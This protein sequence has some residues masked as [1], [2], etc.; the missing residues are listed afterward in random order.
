[1]LKV[2]FAIVAA[3]AATL[4]DPTRAEDI[5]VLSSGAAAVAQREIARQGLGN[6]P[7]HLSGHTITL[8]V[9]PPSAIIGRLSAG[10]RADIVVAP[11]EAMDALERAG[12]LASDSRVAVALV[13]VGIAVRDGAPRPP[14]GTVEDLRRLLLA[15]PSVVHPDPDQP[16]S[17]AGKAITRM[18]DHL[19]LT[20]A[21]APKT[22]LKQAIA[23]GIDMVARGEAAVGL[24]NISEILPAP[25]VALAGPLPNEVQTYI[26]FEAAVLADSP[27]ETVAHTYIRQITARR[28]ARHWEDAG[29]WPFRHR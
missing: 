15:A 19:G 4:P 26:T 20:A 25:G 22:T 23:G 10:E 29:M 3:F 1:M 6:G 9:G 17:V 13:G 5:R 2:M 12:K 7:D 16:G 24:F 28:A 18:L 8:T 11:A 14:L 21:M 27:I